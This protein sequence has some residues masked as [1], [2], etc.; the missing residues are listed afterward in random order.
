MEFLRPHWSW[1]EGSPLHY[2]AKVA[3]AALVGYLLSIGDAYTAMYGAFSA[4]LIVGGSRGEDT[5]T[6]M[7]RVRGSLAGIVVALACALATLPPALG[8]SIGIGATAYVC[9]G[10]GWGVSAARVGATL[11]AATV[12]AHS[13]DALDYTLMRATNTLI[14]IACG[15]LISYFVL[16][17]RGR[18]ALAK[19]ASSAL[20]ACARLLAVLGEAERRPIGDEGLAVLAAINELD[21]V[22]IDARQEFGGEEARLRQVAREVVIGCLGSVTAA[23]ALAELQHNCSAPPLAQLKERALALSRR[24]SVEPAWGKALPAATPVQRQQAEELSLH[25]L[26]LGLRNVEQSLEALGL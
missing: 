4:A 13:N 18:D 8:V 17:V 14:G 26:E 5:G 12:L 10:F 21:K 24:A 20:Q 6:A 15:L 16:P 25:G 7:N 11:C 1:P 2:C 23:L 9:M 3:L 19:S 22:L